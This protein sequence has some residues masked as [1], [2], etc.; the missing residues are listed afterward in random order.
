VAGALFD[1]E[2]F[3]SPWVLGLLGLC[4][5]SFLNVVIHRLPIILDRGWWG[6]IAQQLLDPLAYQRTFGAT[7]PAE[8]QNLG[9]SLVDGL[10]SLPVL[11]LTHPRSRCPACGHQIAWYENLPLLSYIALRGRCAA[12]KTR[13]SPRYPFVE[14]V[15]AGLF[16]A[17]GWRF[18]PTLTAVAWC[19]AIAVLVALAG[20]DWDTTLLP[21]ALTL[22]LLWGGLLCSQFGWTIPLPQ[23]VWGAA[24]GYLSLWSVYWLFKL[25]TGKEGMGYGDFKL[26]AALGAWL[27]WQMVLPIVLSASVIGAVVGIGMKLSS[28]LREGRYVP[29]GPFLAGGGI[30]VMLAGQQR[31]LG[32]LGWA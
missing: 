28:G 4:I 31:V 21:D 10:A 24:V 16:A 27:G 17:V 14:L 23:A 7:A 25:I 22:P 9:K 1:A 11:R 32:W 8:A 5:G 20:I 26:L 15:T 6:D 13:I 18:G 12:C 3:L 19:A 30:A 2:L 29:F